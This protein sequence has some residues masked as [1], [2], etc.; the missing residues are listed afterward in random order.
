MTEAVD[1]ARMSI[2]KMR[3]VVDMLNKEFIGDSECDGTVFNCAGCDAVRLRTELLR[4]I[5]Q[6]E[7]IYSKELD[8]SS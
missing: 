5:D 2:A 8:A 4:M 3:D 7:W 6:V 1:D